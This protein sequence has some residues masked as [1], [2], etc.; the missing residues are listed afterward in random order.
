MRPP[1][2]IHISAAGIAREIIAPPCSGE[3]ES[4]VEYLNSY[5][6]CFF[7]LFDSGGAFSHSR[8][9]I[10]GFQEVVCFL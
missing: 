1:E 3:R 8:S 2:G 6:S 9:R 7:V 5:S 10:F 4:I